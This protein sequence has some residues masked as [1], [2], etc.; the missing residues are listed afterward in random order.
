[1]P[2]HV[3]PTLW[4][5]FRQHSQKGTCHATRQPPPR[6]VSLCSDPACRRRPPAARRRRLSHIVS[7]HRHRVPRR[8]HARAGQRRHPLAGLHHRRRTTDRRRQSHRPA[9]PAGTVQRR[10]RAQQRRHSRR[11]LLSRYLQVDRRRN[12]LRILDR[13]RHPEHNHRAPFAVRWLPPTWPRNTSP[14]NSPTP[15]T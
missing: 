6:A 9:G 14:A 12:R 13:S 15:T 1:M 5:N 8:R 7:D 11:H 4:Y 2:C 3:C 10:S